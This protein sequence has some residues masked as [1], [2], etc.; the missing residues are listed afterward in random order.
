MA[1]D[2]WH[3]S[4][5]SGIKPDGYLVTKLKEECSD[6]AG[7]PTC[8][9]CTK[10]E[11]VFLC[12]HMYACDQA[13]YDYHNGHICKHIHRVHSLIV[14]LQGKGQIT[15]I[16]ESTDLSSPLSHDDALQ[17]DHHTKIT[18][19]TPSAT[20]PHA[21]LRHIIQLEY[22]VLHAHLFAHFDLKRTL[23]LKQTLMIS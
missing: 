13:C 4:S 22:S 8:T 3:V 20:N 6:C 5:L 14:H 11:C 10:R 15:D 1:S 2:T 17:D 23:Q 18:Y 16:T 7:Q 9:P 19:T 21:G 12:W